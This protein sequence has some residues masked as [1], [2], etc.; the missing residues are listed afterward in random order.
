MQFVESGNRMG[1][2]HGSGVG[3]KRLVSRLLTIE[4]RDPKLTLKA[5]HGLRDCGL[6]YA[7]HARRTRKA[8]LLGGDARNLKIVNVLYGEHVCLPSEVER[9]IGVG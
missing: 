8:P 5:R 9:R 7:E 3:E 2:Q 6:R 4:E 1:E